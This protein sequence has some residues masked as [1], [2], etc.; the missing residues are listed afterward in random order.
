[1]KLKSREEAINQYKKVLKEVFRMADMLEDECESLG[2][3][4]DERR[5]FFDLLWDYAEN[6]SISD[7]RDE[8]RGWSEAINERK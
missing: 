2:F 3:N 1:M 4:N 8:V 7:N 6:A 5:Q